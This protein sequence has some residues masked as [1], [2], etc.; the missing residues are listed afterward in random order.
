MSFYGI[1]SDF[2][3]IVQVTKVYFTGLFV[4]GKSI[5]LSV[6]KKF[7]FSVLV[8]EPATDTASGIFVVLGTM[9]TGLPC[10]LSHGL[11]ES[12]QCCPWVLTCSSCED[13]IFT[14]RLPPKIRA[15]EG[16]KSFTGHVNWL[17]PF[18]VCIFP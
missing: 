17:S 8:A 14:S 10:L 13:G 7:G 15:G 1:L 16:V 18:N 2:H 9:A 11:L 5:S 3:V 4:C 6:L 12:Y